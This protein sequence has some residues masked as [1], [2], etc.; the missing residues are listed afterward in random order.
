[1][2]NNLVLFR[3]NMKVFLLYPYFFTPDGKQKKIG[4]V[5]TYIESLADVIL[6]L[7]LTP[8]ICQ[9][10]EVP[11][12]KEYLNYSISGYKVSSIKSL[13]K[14]IECNINK[15]EDLIL[16]VSDLSAVKLK[17]VKTLSIQHGIYWD[18]PRTK[19]PYILYYLQRIKQVF[20]ALID[21]NKTKYSVCVDYNFYNWYKTFNVKAGGKRYWVIPNFANQYISDVDLQKKISSRST[22]LNIIFARRFYKFRGSQ[23][24]TEAMIKIMDENPNINVTFAGEGPEEHYIKKSFERFKDRF[25]MIKYLPSE[26]FEIH[27]KFDIAV[28]PTTGSEGTSLS[29]LEAMGAGC[30][31]VTT[32]VGGLSNIVLDEYNG[33]ISMTTS[34]DLYQTINKAIHNIG[35]KQLVI[36]AVECVKHS[37]SKEKWSKAWE[38][39]FRNIISE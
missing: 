27:K 31:V 8:V 19:G 15:A 37:F 35:N 7:G 10:S 17:G 24:F 14:K 33:Y 36:N 11:F 12:E 39:V 4:G 2:Q 3:T 6:N 21:F 29:L 20:T 9:F 16:F 30:I 5:E 26:S 28:V 38:D 18:I 23:I 34:E 25:S 22:T 13:Y 1:M 32:P